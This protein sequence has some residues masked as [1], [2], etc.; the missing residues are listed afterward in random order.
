MRQRFSP[1]TNP[2]G[3]T[4]LPLSARRGQ[5]GAPAV[6]CGQLGACAKDVPR[7][8]LPDRPWAGRSRG[9]PGSAA[10]LA[11]PGARTSVEIVRSAGWRAAGWL[12][13][14]G[15]RRVPEP[16]IVLLPTVPVRRKRAPAVLDP[17]SRPAAPWGRPGGPCGT[18]LPPLPTLRCP[19]TP[20]GSHHPRPDRRKNLPAD[21]FRC[22]GRMF[23]LLLES[24]YKTIGIVVRTGPFCGQ[25]AFIQWLRGLGC[26]RT[27]WREPG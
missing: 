9:N 11:G 23:L 24:F 22:P 7:V 4:R 18:R 25:A 12:P 8:V 2:V 17:R 10:L 14:T 19:C 27:L 5:I 16:R 1:R 20:G 26:G 6:S 13:S 3:G 21:R 15:A